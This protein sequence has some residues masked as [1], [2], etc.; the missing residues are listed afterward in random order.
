MKHYGVENNGKVTT[1]TLKVTTGAAAGNIPVS[2][3][4]GDLVYVAAGATT[5]I[6][7]GAGAAPPVWTTATGS[8]APVRA[9]T[10]TITTPKID[11][12]NEETGGHGVNIDGVTL[13]DGGALIVTGGTNTFNLTNGTAV[14][15][16]ASGASLNVETASIINQDVTTDANVTFATVTL[17]NT[18]LHILDTNASHDLIIA[19]GSDLTADRT[20]TLS[21]GDTARTI[22]LSGNPTLADWF[23]QAVKSTSSPTFVSILGTT[24]DTNIAAA[25]LTLSGT[26]LAADGTDAAIS[27]NITPKGT[28]SVVI[29]KLDMTSGTLTTPTITKQLW[30]TATEL[31]IA[32]DAITATQTLH[33]IDTESNA[34]TDDL[35]TINGGT[36]GQILVIRAEHTDRTVV[37]KSGTGNI[38]TGGADI[39]LDDTSKYIMLVYDG[40]LSKW[41]I[42]GGSGG[43]TSAKTVNQATHGFSVGESLYLNSTTWTKAKADA[44]A[45]AEAVGMVSTV[46][47]VDTFMLTTNGFVAGLT[48]L[49]AGTVYFLSA[50][51]AGGL[52]ATEPTTEGYVSKPCFIADTTTSGYFIN[53]RGAV[54]GGGSSCYIRNFVEADMVSGVLTVTHGFGHQYCSAPTVIDN[55]GMVVMPDDV[56]YT[57]I[58]AL[59]VDLSSQGVLGGVWKVLVQDSGAATAT[60]T[61]DF[62]DASNIIAGQVF[63]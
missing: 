15:D 3:A 54:V 60:T 11:H 18:G 33:R 7:V 50:T 30:A 38:L 17:N 19:A 1:E 8:G 45:T 35:S 47:G 29:S 62:A 63:G 6:L 13:K 53:M 59:T 57:G 24:F 5:T 61:I 48:G 14:L 4:D 22:T 27:I 12:I 42:I 39:T 55:A 34:A 40:D 46:V 28:G 26:T 36:G 51:T 52:T 37:V 32:S 58:N 10:P 20:L 41:V 56:T 31:T 9:T 21:T 43:G 16:V 23:D 2:D 49:T 25:G 44:V